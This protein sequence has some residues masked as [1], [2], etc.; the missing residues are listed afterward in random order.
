MEGLTECIHKKLI[1]NHRGENYNK[2]LKNINQVSP[3]YGFNF[4]GF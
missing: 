2:T 1:E 3:A 4:M